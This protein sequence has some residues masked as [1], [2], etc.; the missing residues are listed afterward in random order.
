MVGVDA[1]EHF[2]ELARSD[3]ES[4]DYRLGDMRA[5]PVDGPFDAVVSWF[6]SFGYFDDDGNQQTLRE[7]R[8]VLKPGGQLLIEMHNRDEIVR[9]FT[10]APFGLT[11][12]VGEDV[13]VEISEFDC[14]EGRME[15]DRVVIRDGEVRRSHSSIRIPTITELRSWL[16]DAGFSATTFTARDGQAPSIFRP[17]LIALATA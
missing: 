8:R 16:L 1:S 17:R 13:R 4:V 5:L 10:P 2:L 7:Y 3:G 6:T 14:V 9:R 15:T 11:T 12:Q